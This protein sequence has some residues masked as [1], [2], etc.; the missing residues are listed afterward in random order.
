M[1][2]C[3]FNRDTPSIILHVGGI[4]LI[5]TDGLKDPTTGHSIRY[6]HT[7]AFKIKENSNE[8]VKEIV[9]ACSLRNVVI[10]I[11][12]V[13][14]PESS[15][16]VNFAFSKLSRNV[17]ANNITVINY[18][19]SSYNTVTAVKPLRKTINIAFSNFVVYSDSFFG[20]SLEG[21][22]PFNQTFKVSE[23]AAASRRYSTNDSVALN[24]ANTWEG[25]RN[26]KLTANFR[27]LRTPKLSEM[28]GR[29]EN[30]WW[31]K[32]YFAIPPC[33]SVRLIQSTG[34]C[35]LNAL[36]N[37]ILL[38]PEFSN[39]IRHRFP[40]MKNKYG[41][42]R[43]DQLVPLNQFVQR[44]ETNQSGSLELMTLSL[45]GNLIS[46]GAKAKEDDGNFLGA[47]ASIIKCH[48]MAEDGSSSPKQKT[49]PRKSL[50]LPKK[51]T[52]I[53]FGSGG[54][55]DKAAKFILK[56]ILK[57]G[58]DYFAINFNSQDY[59]HAI[60][61]IMGKRY[62]VK[63]LKDVIGSKLVEDIVINNGLFPKNNAT[64][65]DNQSL[66]LSE[67]FFPRILGIELHKKGSWA[68]PEIL[69]LGGRYEYR[70]ISAVLTVK[71]KSTN[72]NRRIFT[73]HA[74]AG[75][76][77]NDQYFVYDSNNHLAKADWFLGQ[78]GMETFF[79]S[80]P[81]LNNYA[82]IS[83]DIIFYHRI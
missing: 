18:T 13:S 28:T 81:V 60:S 76:R 15:K 51:C 46:T 73:Y 26:Q 43:D 61:Q 5:N 39:L 77:C 1:S 44:L 62:S 48:I 75:F 64:I 82:M 74:I 71:Q 31:F 27:F 40:E 45:I 63:I 70:L 19:N 65:S 54:H 21:S 67:K 55:S 34:T 6:Y 12:S 69:M 2:N 24:L 42:D 20:K 57:Q 3:Q 50:I 83:Y 30:L 72:P 66:T 53:E 8:F 56:F 17:V 29:I 47:Y 58:S 52:N 59:G 38:P 78:T 35:W 10:Y 41:I 25:A 23:L 36:L 22:K 4:S 68:I 49:T 79:Q 9:K 7:S 33:A 80:N 11:D 32:L 16:I 14:S 37:C